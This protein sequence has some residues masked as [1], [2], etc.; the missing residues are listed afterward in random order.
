MPSGGGG[1]GSIDLVVRGNKIVL[2]ASGPVPEEGDIAL[3]GRLMDR[4]NRSSV[5]VDLLVDQEQ[6]RVI[7][8]ITRVEGSSVRFVREDGERLPFEIEGFSTTDALDGQY[9][10]HSGR[11]ISADGMSSDCISVV[12]IEPISTT[13]AVLFAG[14]CV[15]GMG[16]VPLVDLIASR[17]SGDDEACRARGGR[18]RHQPEFKNEIKLWPPKI[19]CFIRIRTRCVTFE[20]EILDQTEGEFEPLN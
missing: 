2:I 10:V 19:T 15:I 3:L 11:F 16:V 6:R 20:G 13:A 1:P 12:D 18:L 17:I 7:E 4:T 8:D 9:Q 5:D 14:V